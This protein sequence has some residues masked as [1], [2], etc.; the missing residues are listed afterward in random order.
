MRRR[1]HVLLYTV[2]HHGGREIA[3]AYL[4]INER[5]TPRQD[6]I[7]SRPFMVALWF[8]Y[9]HYQS[10]LVVTLKRL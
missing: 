10:D 5:G 6:K 2:R 9:R 7:I 1:L 8:I 3:I 4:A